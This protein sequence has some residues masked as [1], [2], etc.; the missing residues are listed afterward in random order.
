WSKVAVMDVST[1]AV[2]DPPS[3]STRLT[4]GVHRPSSS[5]R[6][7]RIR[8]RRARGKGYRRLRNKR[9]RR[10]PS[11][12]RPELEVIACLPATESPG[13]ILTSRPRMRA[14][15]QAIVHHGMQPFR[16]RAAFFF[17]ELFA[18]QLNQEAKTGFPTIDQAAVVQQTGPIP[19]HPG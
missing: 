7:G 18:S 2:W 1:G 3:G 10:S 14:D 12:R 6:L 4:A 11:Q 13:E 15:A 8:C 9:V 17:R 16:D 5:S 19:Q